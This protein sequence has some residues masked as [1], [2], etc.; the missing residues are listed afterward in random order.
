MVKFGKELTG[1]RFAGADEPSFSN[2]GQ[3]FLRHHF[4]LRDNKCVVS[5]GLCGGL[6]AN[7]SASLV[8]TSWLF[9]FEAHQGLKW[10]RPSPLPY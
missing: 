6:R 1:R 10:A 3:Y 5:F 8:L 7:G 9:N 4:I 2:S